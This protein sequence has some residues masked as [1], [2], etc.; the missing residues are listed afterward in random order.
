VDDNAATT[1]SLSQYDVVVIARSVNEALGKNW[2][3]LTR[4]VL[5]LRPWLYDDY[6]LTGPTANVDYGW[7]KQST[8]VN[9]SAISHP[10]ALSLGSGSKTVLST[11]QTM[12][13]GQPVTSASI[14][15]MHPAGK[16]VL[17][18]YDAGDALVDGAPAAGCRMAYPGADAMLVSPTPT[19]VT[20][21]ARSME[22]MSSGC[23]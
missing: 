18:T 4:P 20:L 1:T 21:L 10:L 19:G 15:A 6:G 23:P 2:V 22:W 7:T 11:P 9:V 13:F 14:I 8:T 17:F 12:P 5:L 3:S 16:P